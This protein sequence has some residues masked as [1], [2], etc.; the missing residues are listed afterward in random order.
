MGIIAAAVGAGKQGSNFI[1]NYSKKQYLDKITEL[2]G[3]IARLNEHL[4]ELEN[5]RA[6]ISSFW[7][8][9]GSSA[10]LSN[11]DQ[12]ILTT[13]HR[14]SYA[15]SLM[16]TFQKTVDEMDQSQDG[17]NAALDAAKTILSSLGA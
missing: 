11:L 17:L 10:V 6:E 15:Q 1:F 16:E 8:D 4:S 5:L 12:T 3:L 2:E 9:S 14:T 7:N 13:K